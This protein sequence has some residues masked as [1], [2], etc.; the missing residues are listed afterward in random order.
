M[1][2]NAP[3]W[4]S[5]GGAGQGRH[6]PR[7]PAQGARSSDTELVTMHATHEAAPSRSTSLEVVYLSVWSRTA[8]GA[9]HHRGLCAAEAPADGQVRHGH[10][11]HPPVEDSQLRAVQGG[12]DLVP[13]KQHSR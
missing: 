1:A 5:G 3:E 9:E 11:G 6:R 4:A 13:G 8:G 12:G 2:G 10:L 7:P